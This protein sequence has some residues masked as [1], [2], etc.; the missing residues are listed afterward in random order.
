MITFNFP[1]LLGID[2]FLFFCAID[3]TD[4]P[5]K[6]QTKLSEVTSEGS[7]NPDVKDGKYVVYYKEATWES[8]S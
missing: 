6:F 7:I 8:K 5:H 1:F 4:Y 3:Q 2:A